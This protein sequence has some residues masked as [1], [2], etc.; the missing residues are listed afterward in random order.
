MAAMVD[1]VP[2]GGPE[3]IDLR[4]LGARDLEPLLLEETEEWDQ[5]LDWDFSNSADLVRKYADMRAL[6]GCALMDR[7]Q[8]AGYGYAVLE[9]HKGLIGDVYV[10]PG[11]RQRDSEVRLFRSLLDSLIATPQVRRMES[12][13]MLVEPSTAREL[14]R[15]RFVR[16]FERVLMRTDASFAMQP[17]R[18]PAVRRFSI[19]PWQDHHF[20]AASTVI[21]LAYDAHI[22]ARINDQYR[23]FTGARRFLSNIVQFPGCGTFYRPASFAAFD[24]ATGWMAGI[25]LSSFVAAE[26]AHITQ[27]CVTPL[28]KGKGLG[29]ELLH[30]SAEALRAAGARRISLT[31]T[32]ANK[33]AVDLYLRCGFA[34]VRR[35][36]AYV[37]EGY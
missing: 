3:I 30:H 34:E 9:E 2:R 1:P 6:A 12:Q 13:L 25:V 15:E 10:R 19:E 5:Q 33:D 23:T 21:A 7:G 8:A 27:L 4:R 36:F 24:R 37:W 18:N 17:S 31:V 28:G 29:Y 11:W 22:D 26:V 20:D 32:T 14:Q 16:L 35:F